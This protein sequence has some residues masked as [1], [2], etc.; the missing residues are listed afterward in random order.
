MQTDYVH[1]T[2]VGPIATASQHDYAG[3]ADLPPNV[4]QALARL[5]R[6]NEQADLIRRCAEEM[7]TCVCCARKMSEVNPASDVDATRGY[8][9]CG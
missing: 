6:L 1:L 3:L 2:E 7:H 5:D 9:T 8:T 4:V